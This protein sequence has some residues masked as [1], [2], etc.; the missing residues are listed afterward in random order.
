ME[1][2]PAAGNTSI[3]LVSEEGRA[4]SDPV[5]AYSQPRSPARAPPRARAQA[6]DLEVQSGERKRKTV[7]GAVPGVGR[8]EAMGGAPGGAEPETLRVHLVGAPAGKAI[9]AS[10]AGALNALGGGGAVAAVHSASVAKKMLPHLMACL[11][12]VADNSRPLVEA[13]ALRQSFP[14]LAKVVDVAGLFVRLEELSD[15][16]AIPLD[17]QPL[18]GM[19]LSGAAGAAGA[20]ADSFSLF[21]LLRSDVGGPGVPLSARGAL[22]GA[23]WREAVALLA[24]AHMHCAG[25]KPA[26]DQN[27][28][29]LYL[30][31]HAQAVLAR[32]RG[33]LQG[34]ASRI[35]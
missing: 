20:A 34:I 2:V 35:G 22:N 4:D 32:A 31:L 15:E 12:D 18:R 26:S 1:G 29:P 17:L 8:G 28:F 25:V 21:A 24:A 5:V 33:G 9:L 7:G 10:V 30:R 13:A 19:L 14:H 16:Q 23:L 6:R 3:N 27:N 11:S